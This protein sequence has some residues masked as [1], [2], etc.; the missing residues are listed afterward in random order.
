M[1]FRESLDCGIVGDIEGPD[2]QARA[3]AK[4]RACDRGIVYSRRGNCCAQIAEQFE[5]AAPISPAP[6][7]TAA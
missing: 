5:I 3:R 6:P 4:L 1:A 2:C 7:I